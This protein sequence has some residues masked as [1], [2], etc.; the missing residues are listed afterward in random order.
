MKKTN[1][2]RFLSAP[3]RPQVYPVED[4]S[5]KGGMWTSPANETTHKFCKGDIRPR[6]QWP[7]YRGLQAKTAG[8][9]QR[10]CKPRNPHRRPPTP[11]PQARRSLVTFHRWKVTRRRQDQKTNSREYRGRGAN[12]QQSPTQPPQSTI[13]RENAQRKPKQTQIPA[14]TRKG[15]NHQ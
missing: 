4:G 7:K 11:G 8:N 10:I 15:A 2:Y 13:K 5:P 12:P 9:S 1:G 6:G 3:T 14:R